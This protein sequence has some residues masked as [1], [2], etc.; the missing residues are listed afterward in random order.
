MTGKKYKFTSADLKFRR[1]LEKGRGRGSKIS[2]EE[3]Y[4]FIQKQKKWL[5]GFI[6]VVKEWVVE[7]PEE[8][9][10]LSRFVKNI[11]EKEKNKELYKKLAQIK[12]LSVV[13]LE[14]PLLPKLEKEDYIK[15]ELSKPKM[16]RDVV[17]GFT[18]QDNKEDWKEY[19]SC[20]QLKKLLK[21]TLENTNWRL[22]SDGIFYRL[23]ILTGRLR[24]YENDEDL[25]KLIKKYD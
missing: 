15:L 5:K 20:S 14:R 12:K 13:G 4:K 3:F 10:Q 6:K 25:L 22:M 8:A 21:Q 16:E 17:I 18:V 11:E 23:G 7:K 24:G 1:Q 9:E 19:D 2:D